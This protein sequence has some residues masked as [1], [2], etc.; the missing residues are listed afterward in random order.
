MPTLA[1]DLM[2][3]GLPAAVAGRLGHQP[4]SITCAGTAAGTA[5]VMTSKMCQLSAAS[6]QTGAMLPDTNGLCIVNTLSSTSA[7][8]YAPNS[9]T[10]NG[11]ASLTL[12]QNKTAFLQQ[13]SAGV[14]FSALTA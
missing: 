9:G 6:S 12:A 14:W 1:E 10:I 2:G 8:V 7:V 3:V 5:T 4:A 13:F 11:A